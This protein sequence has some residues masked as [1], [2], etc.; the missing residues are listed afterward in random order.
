MEFTEVGEFLTVGAISGY[1][2]HEAARRKSRRYK[3]NNI[4]LIDML[5][6]YNAFSAFDFDDWHTLDIK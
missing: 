5:K 3:V 1:D 4:S 2:F 6:K